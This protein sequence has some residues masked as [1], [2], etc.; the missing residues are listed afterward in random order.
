MSLGAERVKKA[1]AQTLK[2]E[3]EALQMKEAEPLDEFY[4]K[5]N[6]LVTNIR[7]LREKVEETYVVKKIRRAVPTR[8]ENNEGQLLLT[9]EDCLKRTNKEGT[10]CV[11]E[12][13]AIDVNRGIRDKS[14]VRSFNCQAYGH[15]IAECRKPRKER[16]VQKEVNLS[17]IQE[18]EPALLIAET[19]ETEIKSMLL[20][21]D[22]IIPN[23]RRENED[24]RESQ[25]WYL[26]NGA[27][28]HMTGQ[29][30][31]FRELNEQVTGKVKFGDGSTV[32]IKGKG[33]VTF[34]CKNGEERTLTE[35][36]YIPS[37]RNNII[38]LGQLSEAGN[39]VILED[40]YLW[41]YEGSGRLLMKVKKSQ[42]RLYKIS[43]EESKRACLLTKMEKD[44]WSWHARLGQVNFQ[45]LELM[46]RENMAH[47]IPKFTQPLR[48][49]EGCL[50]TKQVMKPFPHQTY[51]E[52][53]KLLELVHA[54]ICGPIS[55][56][57]PRAVKVKKLDDRGKLVVYLGKE[58]RTKGSRLY[59]PKLG[60]VH[61]PTPTS[62]PT[63]TIGTSTG[64]ASG[65][66]SGSIEPKRYRS[67]AE[68]YDETDI[69]DIIDEL[70]LLKT[71]GPSSFKEAIE[72]KEWQ[73]AMKDEFE[74]LKRMV[75]G[76]LQTCQPDINQSG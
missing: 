49:C 34:Q 72:E 69:V 26:D 47:G 38:S 56:V 51:F 68:I 23:L 27:N 9:R 32:N 64:T 50:M 42:N 4:L 33:L 31:K 62:S 1:K 39:K 40:E 15:F 17:K 36:Y 30:G 75:H 43:L 63:T 70:M 10:R 13:C 76:P 8:R 6:S 22:T 58:P 20:K 29:R 66:S 65:S 7:A 57:T 28:N 71:E 74:I 59:D 3:F 37:L 52:S 14:R 24:Q 18:D 53:R 19:G 44:T 73:I 25:V 61:S 60:V 54:D 11:G 35:V 46:S 12:N 48:R 45:A 21:E 16:D 5:L 2:C 67:L 55:P 41:V